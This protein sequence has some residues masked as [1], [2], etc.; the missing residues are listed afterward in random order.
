VS[1]AGNGIITVSGLTAGTA[2]TFT[3]RATNSVG[4]SGASSASNSIT[5]YLL[6]ANSATPVVSGTAT[7]GQTLTTTTGTWTGIPTPTYTYQ[8]KRAG[9]NIGTNSSSYTLVTA[10]IGSTILCVVTAAN[11]AGST[12]ANS[13]ATSAVVAVPV[14][15]EDVF[16][17]SLYTGNGTTQTITNGIDLSDQGGFVWIKNRTSAHNHNLFDT[18]QG[19]TK[20][21]HSN[22]TNATITDANSLTAFRT[23]GFTLGS[24]NTAGNQVNTSGDNFVSWTFRKKPDFFD[25][26]TYTGTGENRTISHNVGNPGV[27]M[28]KR[29]DTVSN[30]QVNMYGSAALGGASLQLNSGAAQSLAPTVWNSKD[31]Q[32]G[33]FE[34]GTSSDTNALGGT[35]IAYVFD[36]QSSKHGLTS[37][38]IIIRC[39]VFVTDGSGNAPEVNLGWEPQFVLIKETASDSS[40]GWII[41]DT[42]RGFSTDASDNYLAPHNTNA[43]TTFGAGRPTA[44]GFIPPP[45]YPT[46]IYAYIAIRRP[47][48][49]PTTG[50]SVFGL[51]ARTGTGANA[52]VTGG[53]GVSDLAIIKNR[54]S[55]P[56]WAW[57]SRLTNTGYLSSNAITA[58]IAAGATILQANPWDVMDGVKVG[59]TSTITNASGNTFINYL[60]KRARGFFDEVCYTGTGS[61]NIVNHNLGVAPEFVIAKS[62][63]GTS[64]WD[65]NFP[66]LG[67]YATLNTADAGFAYSLPVT[68]TTINVSANVGNNPSVTYVAYLFATCP[69]VS[70]V[71][72][73]TGTGATQTIDCGFTG[74]ARFVLIKRTDSTGDWYVWDTARGMVAGTN[75]SLLLNSTAAEVNTNSVYTTGVGFQIVSTVAGINASGGTYIYLAI[76]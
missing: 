74:G 45:L 70:K 5:T 7:E 63:S 50:T 42:M 61:T 3:V 54:G 39:F 16:S 6:P 46:S 4:Q 52:T 59:T 56:V 26:V 49:V 24:G 33:Y 53:A 23:T 15:I 41:L 35:Y 69:G 51:S 8:W 25:V 36:S 47:M 31:I 68:S 37:S 10:D 75:P 17:T 65:C 40:Y 11:A 2:Y 28:V 58:E 73:Y 55:T 19:V 44:T 1:Q 62:R 57:A 30:W 67:R 38:E 76:A 64:D 72:S 32:A 9:V 66:A 13:N 27:V 14:Y 43:E 21:F 71:G 12:S 60:F 34:V 22:T 20:L 48:K 18:N 29:I